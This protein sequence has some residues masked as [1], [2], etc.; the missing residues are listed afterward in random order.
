MHSTIRHLA[1]LVTL[2][3]AACSSSDDPES[4][5]DGDTVTWRAAEG[6]DF[7]AYQSFAVLEADDYPTEL[8]EDFPEDTLNSLQAA[9][10]AAVVELTALGLTEVDPETETPDLYV[11]SVAASETKTG[12]GWECVPGYVWWGW[13][14]SWDPCAWLSPVDFDYTVGSVVVGV[15]DEASQSAVF[16]GLVRGVIECGDAEARLE[17]GVSEI[18][19]NYPGAG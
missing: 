11:F 5:C 16:G 3:T 12:S 14:W 13:F 2:A 8:P 17:S 1:V 9:N 19:A 10:D 18:F 4:I 6:V 15:A 7:G